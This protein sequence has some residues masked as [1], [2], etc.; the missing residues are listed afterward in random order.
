[1]WKPAV[2][3]A[4]LLL[5]VLAIQFW[6]REQSQAPRRAVGEREC[7]KAFVQDWSSD[8]RID[9]TYAKACY[10]AVLRMLPEGAYGGAAVLENDIHARLQERDYVRP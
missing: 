1:V 5:A 10:E 2:A 7:K 3:T 6:P 9:G 8:A 4:A